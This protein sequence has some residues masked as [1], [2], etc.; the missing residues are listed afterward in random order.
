M[1]DKPELLIPDHCPNCASRELFNRPDRTILCLTCG[2]TWK[3]K[4]PHRE[5][6][7]DLQVKAQQLDR[8]ASIAIEALQRVTQ[9]QDNIARS[10]I[11]LTAL[12]R[13][14]GLLPIDGNWYNIGEYREDTQKENKS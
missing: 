14:I 3:R 4:L 2:K 7:T 5:S 6:I 13:I 12:H 9:T 11:A 10:S 8:V 1:T